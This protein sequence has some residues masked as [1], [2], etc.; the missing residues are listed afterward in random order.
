MIYL[1][2]QIVF[3]SLFGL[4]IKWIQSQNRSDLVTVGMI[5]YVLAAVSLL[6]IA[7]ARYAMFGLGNVADHSAA[8][9]AMVTG[10]AMGTS[11]LLAYFFVN[12]SIRTAGVSVTTVMATLS[13]LFPITMAAILWREIPV[14]SQWLGIDL[15]IV[16]I[17]MIVVKWPLSGFRLTSMSASM[18][19]L[20]FFLLCGVNRLAQ[21][22]FKHLS[23][24]EYR[25][26]FLLAAFSCA[27]G[28][29]GIVLLR[30]RKPIGGQEFVLGCILGW[31]NVLQTLLILKC[32]ELYPG[33]LVFT[34]TSAGTIVFT[35][36][37]ST[38]FLGETLSRRAWW[39]IG[40]AILALG[41][42]YPR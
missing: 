15:A 8:T 42:L 16:A 22:A 28:L 4:M 6:V 39:G 20:F 34:L 40:L 14:A 9:W 26:A 10:L 37:V 30:R 31:I 17:G 41:L 11:Y 12:E 7:L 24:A 33:F 18:A 21:D 1:I 3:S 27:G 25:F 13:I 2:L 32:L 29:A 23:A 19:L 5:N 35:V 36:I 38:L